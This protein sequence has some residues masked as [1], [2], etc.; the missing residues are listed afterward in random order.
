VSQKLEG[1][2]EQEEDTS[3]QASSSMGS[4]TSG[5]IPQLPPLDEV[6]KVH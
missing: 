5:T 1:S 2:E 3:L 4:S 6:T